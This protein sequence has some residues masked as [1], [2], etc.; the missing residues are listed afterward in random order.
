MGTAVLVVLLM[1]AVGDSAMA[2]G[3]S[4]S[5]DVGVPTAASPT[6]AQL[7]AERKAERRAAR[8]KRTEEIKK[9]EG[10]GYRPGQ[11]DPNYP[12]NAQN[13][14]KKAGVQ[15]APGQSAP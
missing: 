3:P 14:A 12:A 7:R 8:A 9:L 1:L 6:R 11:N 13:A 15:G 4:G 10:T 2:Q 5:S